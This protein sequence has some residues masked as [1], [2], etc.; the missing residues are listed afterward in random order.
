MTR[1]IDEIYQKYKH[2][3]PF[4]HEESN[5]FFLSDFKGQILLDLWRA[6]KSEAHP[7]PD[8]QGNQT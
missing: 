3:D 2:L 5:A 6:V 8:G 7:D 4:L 1:L